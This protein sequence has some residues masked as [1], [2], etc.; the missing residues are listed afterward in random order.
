MEAFA[1]AKATA[2]R[3]L[4]G[5][6]AHVHLQV[7]LLGEPLPAAYHVTLERQE[8]KVLLHM[9]VKLGLPVKDSL[10]IYLS[11]PELALVARSFLACS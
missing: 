9:G 1:A 6:N 4:V 2:V 8:A 5:V 3:S 11:A 7:L 10:T